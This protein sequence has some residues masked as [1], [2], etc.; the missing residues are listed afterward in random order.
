M[1]LRANRDLVWFNKQI[2]DNPNWAS[3][4]QWKSSAIGIWFDFPTNRRQF[5]LSFAPAM[6]ILDNR[7]FIWFNKKKHRQLQLSFALAME[8]R[9]NRDLVWFNKKNPRQSK[10]SFAPAMEIFDNRD[11]IRFS[12][13]NHR[14]FKLTFILYPNGRL[15][16]ALTITFR[17]NRDLVCFAK[18][19]HRQFKMLSMPSVHAG[20]RWWN[21]NSPSMQ[22]PWTIVV[23]KHGNNAIQ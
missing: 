1:E 15:S 10:L 19:N 22:S 21:A 2:L 14:Q 7:D 16:F 11:S 3:H 13:K 20:R 17:D 12:K 6:E 9:D 18:Q 5:K 23:Y 4:R 8:F